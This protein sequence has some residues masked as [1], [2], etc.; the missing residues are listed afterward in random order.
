MLLNHYGQGFLLVG[1]GVLLALGL[2]TLVRRCFSS[3]VLM[4]AHNATG[5]MLSM[6]GTLYA[7]L[8]GLVVVDAMVRFERAVDVVQ[9]ESTR[10]ADVF[11][12]AERFPEPQQER[13]KDLCRAYA[14]EVVEREWPLMA[15][16][17][18]SLEARRIALLLARS[19]DDFAPRSE[20]EKIVFPMMLELLREVW[21][22][23]RE[24]ITTAQHGIPAIQW[25]VLLIGSIVTILFAGLF[26][27]DSNRLHIL[28]TALGALVLG[29]NIYLAMLFG[30]PYS[31]ALSVSNQPFKTDIGI[32]DGLF[33]PTPAQA[34]EAPT[35][36]L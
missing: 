23:R 15:E 36:G 1:G 34:G 2:V 26:S 13:I 33:T 14:V 21:D 32:F 17:R 18:S 29:L 27:I 10:L 25:V 16:G 28:L 9:A 4:Q 3:A 11:L 35:V 20:T 31:G 7:V 30:Y 8:L 12:L 22:H 19:I 24:R 6:V 5:N